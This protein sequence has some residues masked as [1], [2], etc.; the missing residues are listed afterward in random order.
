M[1]ATWGRG[2]SFC[3][4][5][6]LAACASPQEQESAC[7]DIP[8]GTTAFVN[9]MSS[10]SAMTPADALVEAHKLF[11]SARAKYRD[12]NKLQAQWLL[13]EAMAYF[14]WAKEYPPQEAIELQQQFVPTVQFAQ[15]EEKKNSIKI[16]Q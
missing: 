1:I 8:R 14:M 5:L 7:G 3:L 16:V 12:G 2:L 10:Y 4:F 9:C 6:V 13:E 15:P 11:H